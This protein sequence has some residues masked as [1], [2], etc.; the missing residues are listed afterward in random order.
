MRLFSQL[1][2]GISRGIQKL[3]KYFNGTAISTFF[4]IIIIRSIFCYFN[5]GFERFRFSCIIIW[6]IS[7]MFPY[8]SSCFWIIITVFY[9]IIDWHHIIYIFCIIYLSI[10]YIPYASVSGVQFLNITPLF[11]WSARF[12]ASLSSAPVIV[13][14]PLTNMYASL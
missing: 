6:L 2:N 12:A 8:T 7:I 14:V 10:I 9:Y 5:L 3:L 1:I 11:L 13:I 4:C